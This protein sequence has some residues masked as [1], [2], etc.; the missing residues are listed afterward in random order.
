MFA[1]SCSSSLVNTMSLIQCY[2][3]CVID[4]WHGLQNVRMRQA[5]LDYIMQTDG[6]VN[7]ALER[8]REFLLLTLP[9]GCKLLLVLFLGRDGKEYTYQIRGLVPYGGAVFSPSHPTSA[10]AAG[11]AATTRVSSW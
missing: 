10:P 1:T 5:P 3:L 11:V 2:L 7:R 8:D 6:R 4:K 9:W